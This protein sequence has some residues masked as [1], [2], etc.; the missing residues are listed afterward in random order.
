MEGSPLL[1][2][3]PWL[4]PI[5]TALEAYTLTIATEKWVDEMNKPEEFTF[6]AVFAIVKYIIDVYYI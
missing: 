3:N 6:Y 4:K 5:S 1:L 2:P